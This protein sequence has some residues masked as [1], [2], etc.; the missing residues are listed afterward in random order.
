[1]IPRIEHWRSRLSAPR[2]RTAMFAG[3]LVLAFLLRLAFGVTSDFWGDDEHQIYLIGL[4]FFTT[5][6]WPDFGPDVVY[7]QTQVP[8]GL[9]GL[10]IAGPLWLVQQPEAPYVPAQPAVVHGAVAACLVHRPAAAGVSALVSLVVAD[11]LAVD[12]RRVHARL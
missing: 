7:T 10:L 2:V 11:V 5:G 8:G 3:F 9:Q 1:M 4:K 6:V 12:A